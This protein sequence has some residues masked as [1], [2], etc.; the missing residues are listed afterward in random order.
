MGTAR[1][2]LM[3][4]CAV[5]ASAADDMTGRMHV[6][7]VNGAVCVGVGAAG[8][9][10]GL[11]PIEVHRLG[12]GPRLY[13][14]GCRWVDVQAHDAWLLVS[15]FQSDGGCSPYEGFGVLVSAVGMLWMRAH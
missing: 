7:P 10:G 14:A 9:G 8:A 12:C 6:H 13:E 2:L 15:D 3:K 4:N 5:S 1:C 11:S